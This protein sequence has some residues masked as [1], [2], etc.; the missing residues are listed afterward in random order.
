MKYKIGKVVR[1]YMG[2]GGSSTTS[3]IP[4]WMR[5]SIEN[6]TTK[7]GEAYD[8]GDLSQVAGTS[9]LQEQA[10][11]GAAE[12]IASTG[13]QGLT[14]LQAQQARL[15]KLADTSVPSSVA[16]TNQKNAIVQDAKTRTA[17]LGTQYGSAGT[18]GSARQAVQQGAQNAA[19]TAELAK[20]EA[21]FETNRVKNQ[22]AAEQALGTSVGQAG[23]LASGTASSLASLGGQQRSIEQQQADATWQGIQRLGSTVYGNPARQ[24]TVS[25]GK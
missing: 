6:V 12:N 8:A 14:L 5:P 21:D 4:E 24:Q 16:L 17:K 9:G 15:N 3:T 10:F 23:G 1:R 20:L 2:G 22:L 11:G 13:E 19:T 18:L 7:A 25:G